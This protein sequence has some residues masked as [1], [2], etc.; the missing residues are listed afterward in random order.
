MNNQILVTI[1]IPEI[2]EEYD[3]YLDP[4][5]N[6]EKTLHLLNKGI[7]ELTNNQLEISNSSLYNTDTGKKYNKNDIIIDTD[8]RN[9]SILTLLYK[10]RVK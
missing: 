4:N 9:G 3:V 2:N 8:I 1:K 5:K 6:I 10:K 7:N